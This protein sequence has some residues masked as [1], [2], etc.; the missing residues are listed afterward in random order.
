M[1]AFAAGFIQAGYLYGGFSGLT[2]SVKVKSPSGAGIFISHD[3]NAR[4]IERPAGEQGSSTDST[5]LICSREEDVRAFAL[6]FSF[7]KTPEEVLH[8]KLRDSRTV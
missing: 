2:Q 3:G 8:M 5:T 4:S 1:P 7:G 6:P